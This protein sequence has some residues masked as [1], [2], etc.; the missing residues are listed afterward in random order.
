M[1]YGGPYDREMSGEYDDEGNFNSLELKT[2]ST[3]LLNVS[4]W[5]GRY[6][7][8]SYSSDLHWEGSEHGAY[9]VRYTPGDFAIIQT[10]IVE[11]ASGDC[12]SQLLAVPGEIVEVQEVYR[13]IAKTKHQRVLR[14]KH[15]DY[16][17]QHPGFAVSL[18]EISK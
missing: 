13:D 2:G 15:K 1:F 18:S 14:V 5:V 3:L 16:T 11:H 9:I 7:K 6:V 8:K 10:H 12:P 17:T 4:G